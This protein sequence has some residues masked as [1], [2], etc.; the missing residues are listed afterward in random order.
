VPCKTPYIDHGLFYEESKA[1]YFQE[2]KKHKTVVNVKCAKGY[3]LKGPERFSCH[4][5]EWDVQESPECITGYF[6]SDLSLR[7]K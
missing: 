4:Y 7:M 1:L 3:I 6:I 5:G 2:I